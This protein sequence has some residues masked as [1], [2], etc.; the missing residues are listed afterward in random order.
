MARLDLPGIDLDVTMMQDVARNLG[1]KSSQITTL[2]NEQATYAAITRE[3]GKLSSVG[4]DDQVLVYF[5]G[6]GA[7]TPDTNGDEEDGQDEILIP[8]DVRTDGGKWQNALLDD[9]FAKLLANIQS[10]RLLLLIDACHSGT[11]T[12][13]LSNLG[14]RGVAKYAR[15]PG[16]TGKVAAVPGSMSA[17]NLAVVER[18]PHGHVLLSAALDNEYAQAT[19][20]GSVFTLGVFHAVK[21]AS[22]GRDLTPKG[23]AKNVAAFVKRTLDELGLREH[24]PQ[25]S[26]DDDR[27]SANLFFA[28]PAIGPTRERLDALVSQMN[29]LAA[30]AERGTYRVGEKVT[31]TFEIP[32][33]GYL[34]VVNL[35]AEDNAVVLFPNKHHSNNRVTR[36]RVT[37]P[38][39]QMRFDIAV[40]EPRGDNITYAILSTKPVDLYKSTVKGRDANGNIVDVLVPLSPSGYMQTRN[41]V[42]VARIGGSQNYAGKLVLN[43]R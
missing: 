14:Q 39:E 28:R 15:L 17:R 3:I 31:M 37:I 42:P 16:S 7:H 36:G 20:E 43:V 13:S 27:L 1:F 29:S 33:D 6:H 38:T 25:L 2:Q 22:S 18:Q 8:H 32:I 30:T 40:Q 34:N 5:S 35:N 12:K 41:L 21:D 10:R 23:L 24:T 26:G 4:R 9:D 19:K 11:A